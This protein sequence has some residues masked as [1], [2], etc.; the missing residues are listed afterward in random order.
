MHKSSFRLVAA[1]AAIALAVT[2]CS[3]GSDSANKDTK[4]E[5][6]TWWSS[7]G[8]AAGLQGMIDV[9]TAQNPNTEFINAAVA[10]GAGVNAKAVLT[11][12]LEANDPPDSFQAHAGMELDGYVK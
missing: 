2:G 7:G 1:A 4:F 5:I 3:S 12:R 9:Y 11:S 10:G 8:E 6:F